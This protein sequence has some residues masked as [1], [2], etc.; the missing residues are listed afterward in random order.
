MCFACILNLIK[1]SENITSRLDSKFGIYHL[2]YGKKSLDNDIRYGNISLYRR[3]YIWHMNIHIMYPLSVI[4]AV[5]RDLI[6]NAAGFVPHVASLT[7]YPCF[8][9]II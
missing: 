1:D 2:D 8:Q 5:F 7:L 6:K 9:K 3:A 4:K